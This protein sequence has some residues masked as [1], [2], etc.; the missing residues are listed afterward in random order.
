MPLPAPAAAQ[1]DYFR[2]G[3]GEEPR[4]PAPK[5]P[6][7]AAGPQASIE[8]PPQPPLGAH[9]LGT[10]Q[11]REDLEKV[12]LHPPEMEPQDCGEAI[13]LP[14]PAGI[15]RSPLQSREEEGAFYPGELEPWGGPH[16][17]LIDAWEPQACDDAPRA[18]DGAQ[19]G[20]ETYTVPHKPLQPLHLLLREGWDITTPSR[21][22]SRASGGDDDPIL[23]SESEHGWED[24]GRPRLMSVVM[25][26]PGSR[27]VRGGSGG[28]LGPGNGGN[29]PRDA[30]F[31]H[32]GDDDAASEPE[33]DSM[34]GQQGPD[35]E[36]YG[37][38][39]SDSGGV[40]SGSEGAH[41]H[42]SPPS[43]SAGDTAG[44]RLDPEFVDVDDPLCKPALGRIQLVERAAK[45]R[46]RALRG[47]SG[48]GLPC[49]T[50]I[51]C[52]DVT[53]TLRKAFKPSIRY[54]RASHTLH[55]A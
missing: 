12:A 49:S 43:N 23:L 52:R 4:E 55:C 51:S 38:P 13:P 2:V 48:Y 16:S 47:E 42:R 30:P 37:H 40:Q 21:I 39:R 7:S 9:L 19:A 11:V 24:D 20:A 33:S 44:M 31:D 28:W 27:R 53:Q 10:T 5:P 25:R 32:E 29:D 50:C 17:P 35:A 54:P 8:A 45:T 3:E 36:R 34:S 46:G 26:N 18:A 14:A 15:L 22:P 1:P 6:L 41:T